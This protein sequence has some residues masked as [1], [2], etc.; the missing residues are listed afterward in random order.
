MIRGCESLRGMAI[1]SGG[2]QGER[3]IWNGR[4][5]RGGIGTVEGGDKNSGGRRGK[6]R[7]SSGLEVRRGRG[8]RGTR[9]GKGGKVETFFT[10]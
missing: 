1:K 6:R 9:S 2:G 7:R 4:Q 10:I 3:G 8:G 5:R